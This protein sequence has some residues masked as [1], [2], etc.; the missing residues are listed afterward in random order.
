[1]KNLARSTSAILLFLFWSCQ[2]NGKTTITLD[3]EFVGL[4]GY[5]SLISLQSME[6]TLGHRYQY[7]SYLVHMDGFRREWSDYSKIVEEED[8]Q[9]FFYLEGKDTI[10]VDGIISLNIA[11]KEDY[12]IN[13][14][15]YLVK[16][17]ELVKFD[18][19][20]SGYFRVDVTDKISDYQIKGSKVYT[21]ESKTMIDP[22][23]SKESYVITT[24][25]N[26]LVNFACDSI[27]AEF[28]KEFDLTTIRP[29]SLIRIRSI[30]QRKQ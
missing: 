3:D 12:R 28:R 7:A 22:K 23:E 2:N 18:E 17:E 5:G 14:V 4:I 24:E 15:L 1:M 21:Y 11:P 9:S 26:D 10:S 6:E 8:G 19:R 29:D 13:C 20:E 25:Y 16:R 30:I 27:G